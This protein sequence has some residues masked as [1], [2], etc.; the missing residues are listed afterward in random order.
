MSR[1]S[2]NVMRMEPEA[3]QPLT[4]EEAASALGVS[5]ARITWLFTA[6]YIAKTDASHFDPVSVAR[7]RRW[8][9]EASVLRRV[10]RAL[11]TPLRM[12]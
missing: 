4:P 12:V 1:T 6:D 7:Y 5:V 10:L 8:R 2:L 3:Q 11:S 9:E